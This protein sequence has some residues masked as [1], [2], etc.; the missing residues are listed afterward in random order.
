MPPVQQLERGLTAAQIWNYDMKRYNKAVAHAL[1]DE[2]SE[3][4][5]DIMIKHYLNIRAIRD[6]EKYGH[7]IDQAHLIKKKRKIHC[8][9]CGHNN[10]KKEDCKAKTNVYGSAIETKPFSFNFINITES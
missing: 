6:F 5:P 9:Y 4:C 8:I 10:H 1:K 7:H 3:I 2:L